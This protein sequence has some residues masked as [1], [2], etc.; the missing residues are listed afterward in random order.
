M[1]ERNKKMTV[2]MYWCLFVTF[3]GFHVCNGYTRHAV[4]DYNSKD[5]LVAASNVVSKF[6]DNEIRGE[7]KFSAR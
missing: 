5:Y 2:I 3:M 6:E 7:S 4:K 1:N